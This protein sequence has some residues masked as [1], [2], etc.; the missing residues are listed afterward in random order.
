MKRFLPSLLLL[1]LPATSQA[2]NWPSFRGPGASGLDPMAKPPATWNVKEGK[3]V[4]WSVP[5]PGFAHS[6]PIVWG[7]RV[8]VATAVHSEKEPTLRT[9]LYGDVDSATDPG[10]ISWRLLAFE[11]AT[12]K[13]VWDRELAKGA[14]KVLR[15]FKAT[16]ANSTPATDGQHVV[17][18]FG[19]EGGLYCLSQDGKLEWRTEVGGVDTGWFYD[20][21]YQ[22][23]HASSPVIWQNQ[24][25]LQVDRPKDSFLAAYDLATGKPLWRT[26]RAEIS[27]WGTPTLVPSGDRFEIVT[28]GSRAIRGYDPKT[29]EELWHISPTTE[30]SVSTP[31]FAGGL[32][33]VSE[34]Y[35][36]LQPVYAIRPGG[37][38]D[39][40]LK[41]D[42]STSA[43]IAWSVQKGGT[44]L[45][46]PIA[47]GPH[48]YT[49][50][51]NGTLTC[52]EAATG[53]ELY[54]QRVGD[55]HAAF[56]ASPVATPERLYLASEDGDVFVVAT[57]PE[58]RVLG[59]NPVG[60]TLMATPAI[61]G[62]LLILRTG[63]SLVA[64]GEPAPAH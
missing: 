22:W 31:I 51:N 32:V 43:Q 45:P 14:P 24:V 10:Q 47:V 20:P 28:N 63:K 60:E 39:L 30:V 64:V 2:Q 19:S 59:S 8:F 29:G 54:R 52:Y 33:F 34:G 7:D 62:D 21:S 6:S 35:R 11:R 17:V 12:G 16:H 3:N 61:S 13:L 57:G 53:K 42:A 44:Y 9:G 36:P 4:R 56:S 40:S 38:G 55:G 25:I 26:P 5:V 23:G 15:H 46:T 48:L 27:S 1:L 49:L 18:F 58:F 50:N 37:R 41:P